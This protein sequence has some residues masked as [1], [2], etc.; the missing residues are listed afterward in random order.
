MVRPAIA[1]ID[2]R[3]LA[4][5]YLFLQKKSYPATVVAV[6]KANAYGHGLSI[7]SQ[8]LF[9]L[10]CRY[11]AVT[12][13]SEAVILRQSLGF[14]VSII[15]LSG[16]F[17]PS[18]AELCCG[19]QLTPFISE[20][21]QLSWLA[22]YHFHAQVWLKVNS[23]MNR[24]GCE[25]LRELIY[26]CQKKGIVVESICSHLACADE[27]EHLLNHE[28]V[29]F[30]Q[31]LKEIFSLPMSLLNSAGILS[32]PQF[33]FEFVRPG[34][35]L[36]GVNPFSSKSV[37]S[38][39]P[40]MHLCARIMQ[41]RDVAA[42]AYI[43]YG[44]SFR[45]TDRMRIALVSLGYADGLVRSLSNCGYASFEGNSFP[46]VGRV[47]MDYCLLDVG[48]SQ[49]NVGDELCF[50]GAYPT[51]FD[52]AALAHTISYTLLTGVGSRVKRMVT[53]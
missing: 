24:L 39:K 3:A 50:F 2:C 51:A 6:V 25:N 52:V 28:Q 10:G 13:V 43:S 11:F 40:V 8:E 46:I 16:L 44:G 21:S 5:N 35:A 37:L 20:E 42:G 30:M 49:V 18:E 27:P 34:L 29:R 7:I 38:L 9:K 4:H 53:P 22:A 33:S 23:G 14:D 47:C 41:I 15:V 12:D 48:D 45:A 26:S 36:Y 19:Y 31:D 32:M 1:Y 17:D